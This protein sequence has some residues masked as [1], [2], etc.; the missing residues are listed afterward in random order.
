MKGIIYFVIILITLLSFQMIN[1]ASKE[2][3]TPEE[4][5][6]LNEA[7]QKGA[8]EEQIKELPTYPTTVTAT[9]LFY[10][11]G[12]TPSNADTF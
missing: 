7:K 12:P 11:T 9:G 5:Q 6:W 10:N 4:Q 8:S 3:I 1:A 2:D